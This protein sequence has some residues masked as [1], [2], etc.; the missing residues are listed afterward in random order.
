MAHCFATDW[1][2]NDT[3]YCVRH[4]YIY[5]ESGR[6]VVGSVVGRW[7]TSKWYL[8]L[9]IY[10][11]LFVSNRSQTLISYIRDRIQTY[12]HTNMRKLDKRAH[13]ERSLMCNVT[14]SCGT[15][16]SRN[17]FSLTSF[18]KRETYV[19]FMFNRFYVPFTILVTSVLKF[20]SYSSFSL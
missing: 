20:L 15:Q 12:T 7:K 5:V 10:F 4:K 19:E 1:F 6:F 17:S 2:L 9:V 8:C 16:K 14:N 18:T 11:K 13:L 3:H